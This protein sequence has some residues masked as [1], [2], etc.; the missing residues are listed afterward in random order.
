MYH[1]TGCVGVEAEHFYIN[2]QRSAVFILIYVFKI[3]FEISLGVTER[4]RQAVIFPA[5]IGVPEFDEDLE[6]PDVVIPVVLLD[7]SLELGSTG[8]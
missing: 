8:R 5:G 1:A 2:V 3:E 7:F 6:R 4:D